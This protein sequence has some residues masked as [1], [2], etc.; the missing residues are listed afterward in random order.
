MSVFNSP[1]S[2]IHT[3][4]CLWFSA[5]VWVR[6][7]AVGNNPVQDVCLSSNTE[8]LL[9]RLADSCDRLHTLTIIWGEKCLLLLIHQSSNQVDSDSLSLS[10]FVC[11]GQC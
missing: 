8:K 10:M 2:W 11:P 3:P 5:P 9:I 4:V 7:A 6:Q 1:D